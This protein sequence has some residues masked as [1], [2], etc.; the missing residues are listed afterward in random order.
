[1]RH[2][3]LE[4]FRATHFIR[5]AH[6][7]FL[8]GFS[9]ACLL[10]FDA[11]GWSNSAEPGNLIECGPS[12]LDTKSPYVGSSEHSAMLLQGHPTSVV[13]VW[14]HNRFPGLGLCDDADQD[15]THAT[16]LL[17]GV[18]APTKDESSA[19]QP[20]ATLVVICRQHMVCLQPG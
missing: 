1:V 8:Y 11:T 12:V 7:P 9:F 13:G 20:S 6:V 10:F 4:S 3:F 18:P 15:A 14:G 17:R 16:V 19:L 5:S 2:F